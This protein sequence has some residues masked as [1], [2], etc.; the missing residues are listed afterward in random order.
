MLQMCPTRRKLSLE[1]AP[2]AWASFWQ[3]L[4]RFQKDK[5]YPWLA[6]RNAIGVMAPLIAGAAVGQLPAGLVVATGAL[7]VA[8]SDSHEPYRVRAKR[9]LASSV[10]VGFAV[11][12]GS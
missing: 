5:V 4:T 7:N 9:M 8:W 1:R 12:T 2:N 10:L 6:L 3:A 11:F